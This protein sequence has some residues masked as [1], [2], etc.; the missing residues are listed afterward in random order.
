MEQSALRLPTLFLLLLC[1]LLLSKI[2]IC[3]LHNFTSFRILGMK[4]II[5]LGLLLS[6]GLALFGCQDKQ[7]IQDLQSLQSAVDLL[8]QRF[9]DGMVDVDDAQ[10]EIRQLI[11]TY[12][13]LTQQEVAATMQALDRSLD[14]ERQK[15]EKLGTLPSRA[16]QLGLTVPQGMKLQKTLS[17]QVQAGTTGY[18]SFVLVYKGTYEKAVQEAQRIASGAKLFLSPEITQAQALLKS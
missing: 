14:D 7:H 4:K 16:L 8:Q 3:F 2:K 12:Q 15:I 18:D 17:R 1:F 6:S 10:K 5:F 11:D 13:T 9:S